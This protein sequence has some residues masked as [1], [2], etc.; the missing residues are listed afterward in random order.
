M[1]L[2]ELISSLIAPLSARPK[3]QFY[4]TITPVSGQ[5]ASYTMPVDGWVRLY[6]ENPTG[7]NQTVQ[8][9]GG[10]N[11]ATLSTSTTVQSPATWSSSAI[12]FYRKGDLIFYS[13]SGFSEMSLNIFALV[14]GVLKLSQALVRGGGLCLKTFS[15]RS[16]KQCL[17]TRRATLRRNVC[18]VGATLYKRLQINRGQQLSHTMG[19]HVFNRI[20]MVY[21]RVLWRLVLLLLTIKTTRGPQLCCLLKKVNICI[22]TYLKT[23]KAKLTFGL[24]A[25]KQTNNL[26]TEVCHG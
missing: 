15:A 26:A 23:S 20:A 22:G 5:S 7:S 9:W 1:S 3:S 16:L 13:I 18:Q 17:R 21:K 25:I 14:G 12:G 24:F 4:Q 6:G 11:Q 10:E 8:L 2:K 19:G